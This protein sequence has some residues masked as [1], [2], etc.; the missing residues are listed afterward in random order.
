M[1]KTFEMRGAVCEIETDEKRYG[2]KQ[3]FK[4][5]QGA[6]SSQYVYDHARNAFQKN[7]ASPVAEAIRREF[8]LK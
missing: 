7:D 3:Y 4:F 2:T 1:K 6:Q 8:G 5:R